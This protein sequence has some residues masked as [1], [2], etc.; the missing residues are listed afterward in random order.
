M[1]VKTMHYRLDG[2]RGGVKEKRSKTEERERERERDGR[3][4]DDK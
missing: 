2:V 3:V 1:R 4:W